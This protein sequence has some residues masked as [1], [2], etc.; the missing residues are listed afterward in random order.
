MNKAISVVLL[1]AGALLIGSGIIAANAAG[2]EFLLTFP[3]S[4]PDKTVWLILGGLGVAALGAGGL[5]HGS[6][7]LSDDF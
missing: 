2:S 3:D 1:V 5:L 6:K 4:P 7:Y